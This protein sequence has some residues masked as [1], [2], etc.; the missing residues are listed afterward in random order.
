MRTKREA[1]AYR[2]GNFDGVDA[3]NGDTPAPMSD[4]GKVLARAWAA[5]GEQAELRTDSEHDEYF[6]G[7]THGYVTRA[8]GIEDATA[9]A[10]P[11]ASLS[12]GGA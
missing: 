2:W 7:W 1:D 6:I 4:A 8:E 11:D 10:R 9:S 3:A 5:A 12:A